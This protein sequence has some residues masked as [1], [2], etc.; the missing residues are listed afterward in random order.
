M[1]GERAVLESDNVAYLSLPKNSLN[2]GRFGL[3]KICDLIGFKL[4]GNQ[5]GSEQHA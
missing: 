2:E 1:L 3:A 4:L 5:R